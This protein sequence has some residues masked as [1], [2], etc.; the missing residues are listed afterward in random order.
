LA[1]R[2]RD[3]AAREHEPTK[4]ASNKSR[5]PAV[6]EMVASGSTEE[7]VLADYLSSLQVHGERAE[8]RIDKEFVPWLLNL[9][10]AVASDDSRTA[11]WEKLKL[12]CDVVKLLFD[13]YL[14][15]YPEDAQT[16]KNKTTADVLKDSC[17]FL[18][19][20]LDK[21][22]NTQDTFYKNAS[23]L[24]NTPKLKLLRSLSRKINTVFDEPLKLM[25]TAQRELKLIR[26][27]AEKMGSLKTEAKDLYLHS[28]ATRVREATGEYHF[29]E[30]TTLAE[31]ALAAHGGADEEP[32]DEEALTKR[33]QRY[34]TRMNLTRPTHA[35]KGS[36]A[37]RKSPS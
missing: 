16:A 5:P 1:K 31:A 37:N 30:L 8:D 25:E 32:L 4:T 35:I 29:P 15:T 24:F 33:V 34:I 7:A 19:N 21:L 22:I 9:A 12:S 26:N 13:L 27:W 10:Q 3:N 11:A 2:Q 14:F 20:E 17:R 18:K 36:K 6:P 23:E 28:M